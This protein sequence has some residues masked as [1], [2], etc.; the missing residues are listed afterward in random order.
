MEGTAQANTTHRS[1]LPSLQG[2]GKQLSP[3][4]L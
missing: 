4:I 1:L 3:V 2:I